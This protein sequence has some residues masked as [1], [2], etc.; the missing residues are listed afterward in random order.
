[1]EMDSV[2]TMNQKLFDIY[3]QYLEELDKNYQ[4]LRT[5][6][7]SYVYCTTAPQGWTESK[8]RFLIIG[9]EGYGRKKRDFL[10]VEDEIQCSQGFNS[11]FLAERL[12]DSS[13]YNSR[14]WQWLRRIS[15]YGAC[16]W[17]NFD[18]I[19]YQRNETKK[20][21]N[22]PLSKSDREM[23]HTLEPIIQKEIDILKPTMV[24]LFG[25]YWASMKHELPKLEETL[26]KMDNHP[27][28]YHPVVVEIDSI[29]FI[30]S[31]HPSFRSKAYENEVFA[32][33][34]KHMK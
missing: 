20:K 28:R 31:Y 14:F 10:T 19:H 7:Y 12:K 29:P 16:S 3:N 15:Q 32:L 9:K 30:A 11:V 13:H 22:C 33:I 34:E 21:N 4:S 27:G 2:D 23:L 5:E 18:K 8:N 6:K 17:S 26:H 24:I 25:W 1:M